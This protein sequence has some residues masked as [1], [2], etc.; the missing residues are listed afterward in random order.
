MND[1]Q[2]NELLHKWWIMCEKYNGQG[3]R[4]IHAGAT[5]PRA[6]GGWKCRSSFYS[7]LCAELPSGTLTRTIKLL[8]QEVRIAYGAV[9]WCINDEVWITHGERDVCNGEWIRRVFFACCALR[10]RVGR[11]LTK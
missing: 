8:Q 2:S 4:E 9:G 1:Y 11:V 7:P 3:A 6:C 5:K 10:E